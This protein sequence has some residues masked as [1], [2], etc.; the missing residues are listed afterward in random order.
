MKMPFL[1]YLFTLCITLAP[2]C[3]QIHVS[4]AGNDHSAGKSGS[5]VRTFGKA[6]ELSRQEG[7][8]K[9]IRFAK[10]TYFLGGT[11]RLDGRDNGLKMTGGA[12]AVLS[13]GIRV[14]GWKEWERG[15]WR[16]EEPSAGHV[17]ELF[18]RSQRANRARFPGKGWL[19][20]EKSHPDRRSGFT[21]NQ[22]DL[23]HHIEVAKGLELVFLHDWSISRIPV[24]SIQP[25]TRMLEAAFPIGCEAPHYAIDH[26]EKQPR[27]AL[28]GSL[29]LLDQPG[30]WAG[31]DGFLYYL[32][33]QGEDMRKIQAIVPKLGRLLEISAGKD[34]K[35]P[36]DIKMDGLTFAHCRWDI[37][38]E[39]YASGQASMHEY[40]DGTGKKA[41]SSFPS[42]CKSPEHPEFPL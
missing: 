7:N 12:G 15:I 22:G 16:A 2:I 27:Y 38:K 17:R 9:D 36:E 8:P 30:E 33:K 10:G 6:L 23:P 21:Y 29:E 4:P 26:F 39:G 5:P 32:P 37:P 18:I 11:I 41:G 20:I 14:Q 1:P 34:G 25:K 35:R 31:R 24:A 13:G 42:Q 28:E 19:R 40:R 3:G